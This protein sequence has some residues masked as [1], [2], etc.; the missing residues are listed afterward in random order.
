MDRAAVP[1]TLRVRPSGRPELPAATLRRVSTDADDGGGRRSAGCRTAAG[2]AA[3]GVADP[4]GA[5]DE[6]EQ[7]REH[8]Q[9]ALEILTDLG[10]DVTEDDEATT[11]AIRAHLA[12]LDQ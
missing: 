6:P 12:N 7:A 1:I 4:G 5:L 11:D 8:W 3:A 2:V 10:V 9:R